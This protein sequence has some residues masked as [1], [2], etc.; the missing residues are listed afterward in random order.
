M[1][2]EAAIRKPFPLVIVRSSH[3]NIGQARLAFAGK[4]LKENVRDCNVFLANCSERK[5]CQPT[6]TGSA[7]QHNPAR[8]QYFIGCMLVIFLFFF[9]TMEIF[10]LKNLQQKFQHALHCIALVV[11]ELVYR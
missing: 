7:Q 2:L 10:I 3:Q 6:N 9:E 5:S 11:H 1:Y 8:N 4:R